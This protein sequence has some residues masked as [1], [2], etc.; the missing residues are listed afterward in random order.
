MDGTAFSHMAVAE[1]TH[2]WFVG[3]RAVIDSLLDGIDLPAS[4]QI[5]EAGCGTGGNLA[6]LSRRGRIAAFEPHI[7]ALALARAKH[8]E[9]EIREAALPH[10]L[11]YEPGS[12][13]LVAALDVLEHVGNDVDAAQALVGL[14]RPGGWLLVTVPAHQAL[15]GSH[16]R[17]LHH[18]RRYGRRQVLSLFATSEMELIRFTPFNLVLSPIAVVYRVAERALRIDLGNQERIPPAWL[19]ALLARTFAFE[20]VLLHLGVPLPFGLSYAAIFRRRR[21]GG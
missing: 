18:M 7:D 15:W 3:R 21:N 19:N 4:G 5:L 12:F 20:S 17:R 6:S 2:W 10:P 13:D 14:V 11:P 1:V 8:P 16:D 9:V